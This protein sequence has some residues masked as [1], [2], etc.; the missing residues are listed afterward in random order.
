MFENDIV[1]LFETKK[2]LP[3]YRERFGLEHSGKIATES[4]RDLT[5]LTDEELAQYRALLVKS[6]R[7]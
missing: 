3:E 4:E 2:H 5:Q 6:P 1:L 7:V